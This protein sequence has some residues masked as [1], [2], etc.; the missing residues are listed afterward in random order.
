MV[1]IQNGARLGDMVPERN[2]AP[3]IRCPN[4]MVTRRLGAQLSNLVSE[5]F[6][7]QTIWCP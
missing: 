6:G 5:R 7:A 3:E 4:E 1:P 2:G